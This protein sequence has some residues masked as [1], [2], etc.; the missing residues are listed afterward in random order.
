[1]SFDAFIRKLS[2]RLL[3]RQLNPP[4]PTP[5][6][7]ADLLSPAVAGTHYAKDGTPLPSPVVGSTLEFLSSPSS[8]LS[9]PSVHTRHPLH[10][11]APRYLSAIDTLHRCILFHNSGDAQLLHLHNLH[12]QHTQAYDQAY[13]ASLSDSIAQHILAQDHNQLANPNPATFTQDEA[14]TADPTAVAALDET[15]EG[16]EADDDAVHMNP[17]DLISDSDCSSDEYSD[18]EDAH[19]LSSEEDALSPLPRGEDGHVVAAK[20]RTPRKFATLTVEQQ[21]TPSGFFGPPS[22][23]SPLTGAAEP[24]PTSAQLLADQPRTPEPHSAGHKRH[25]HHH[26]DGHHHHHRSHSGSVSPS[27]RPLSPVPVHGAD[28][29]LAAPLASQRR[30]RHSESHALSVVIPA[31]PLNLPHAAVDDSSTSS[32]AS[33]NPRP[34]AAP[35]VNGIVPSAVSSSQS[36]KA[37]SAIQPTTAST[38]A[39]LTNSEEHREGVWTEAQEAVLLEEIL[40]CYVDVFW[41]NQK[42]FAPFY[43]PKLHSYREKAELIYLHLMQTRQKTSWWHD[44]KADWK[45]RNVRSA[46]LALFERELERRDKEAE[47]AKHP[48][49]FVFLQHKE[50]QRQASIAALLLPAPK[51]APDDDEVE[52][53]LA[54]LPPEP[55]STEPVI[56]GLKHSSSQSHIPDVVEVADVVTFHIGAPLPAVAPKQEPVVQPNAASAASGEWH[57]AL[58]R[59]E[60]EEQEQ[61]RRSMSKNAPTGGSIPAPPLSYFAR[62][63]SVC[64]RLWRGYLNASNTI[65]STI[66]ERLLTPTL[67]DSIVD[68]RDLNRA[69]V[70]QLHTR[71]V[72]S[73]LSAYHPEYQDATCAF[74]GLVLLSRTIRQRVESDEYHPLGLTDMIVA[75]NEVCEILRKAFQRVVRTSPDLMRQIVHS[76]RWATLRQLHEREVVEAQKERERGAAPYP[77]SFSFWLYDSRLYPRQFTHETLLLLRHISQP[78]AAVFYAISAHRFVEA[79]HRLRELKEDVKAVWLERYIRAKK[80]ERIDSLA[81]RPSDK[82][83]SEFSLGSLSRNSQPWR[84]PHASPFA[85]PAASPATSP[86][87]T[88]TEIGHVQKQDSAA[89]LS[90]EYSADTSLRIRVL[91]P[92]DADVPLHAVGAV[93]ASAKAGAEERKSIDGAI[94]P[95]PEPVALDDYDDITA[96]RPEY[97]AGKVLGTRDHT[98]FAHIEK[99]IDISVQYV[100]G[101]GR[102]GPT[103]ALE[104]FAVYDKTFNEPLFD[105]LWGVLQMGL[106]SRRKIHEH[107]MQ[108]KQFKHAESV[109]EFLASVLFSS[110]ATTAQSIQVKEA[111]FHDPLLRW[112]EGRKPADIAH[113][114][115]PISFDDFDWLQMMVDNPEL[116]D[117]V[118]SFTDM[119]DLVNPHSEKRRSLNN[120]T[121]SRQPDGT[122]LLALHRSKTIQ[123]VKVI[124]LKYPMS[125]F[126]NSIVRASFTN[127]IKGGLSGIPFYGP[128]QT[129]NALLER[130]FDFTDIL[131]LQRHQQALL[132][133]VEAM[134]GNDNSPFSHPLFTPELLDK[135][136]FYLLRTNIMLSGVIVN[137]ATDNTRLVTNYLSKI[138]RKREVSMATLTKRGMTLV[139]IPCSYYCITYQR[140][141]DGTLCKLKIHT[142]CFTKIGRSKKPHAAV[143]FFRPHRERRKRL[144]LQYINTGA[145]FLYVPFPGIGGIAKMAYKEAIVREVHKRQ[146]WEN[147]LLAHISHNPGQLSELF[148]THLKVSRAVGDRYEHDAVMILEERSL[149]P[150]DMSYEERE[151][152]RE[153]VENWIHQHDL[154]YRP[155]KP[156]YDVGGEGTKVSAH[157]TGAA[158]GKVDG[159]GKKED[160]GRWFQDLISGNE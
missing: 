54:I 88:G 76:E 68:T 97:Y 34:F 13:I 132:L 146:M 48:F 1:M 148:R 128:T 52:V 106:L 160:S 66:V 10:S 120:C 99:W 158:S 122:Y 84:S 134:H 24:Q 87:H 57:P 131:Y 151:R 96:G 7:S 108:I 149:S 121:F 157:S 129:A 16:A 109:H 111:F 61:R 137:A 74:P 4:A 105:S 27:P 63:N 44:K 69:V 133:V 8:S 142:L 95:A 58:T 3:T 30:R 114:T 40:L 125:S 42:A 117:L 139:L 92:S 91:A 143:D 123:P 78:D 35:T 67:P 28:G 64:R 79:V 22:P 47:D 94:V 127:A 60:L 18:E 80:Q 153:I 17:D 86:V 112:K 51:N 140:D 152:H 5:S 46:V 150:F 29:T 155:L 32:F 6:G 154:D 62:L 102:D 43:K 113:H 85:S 89:S 81:H 103:G 93:K 23:L 36:L 82:S 25:H 135:A 101:F 83:L 37:P 72:L 59:E 126:V 53:E 38:S 141:R 19:G 147:G 49:H 15:K 75:V 56:A 73:R 21:A 11:I 110:N 107:Q 130:I 71:A 26:S 124:D 100:V 33:S 77:E 50:M 98:V 115:K 156:H 14:A 119:N 39:A 65:G 45:A 145:N 55:P 104:P 31:S 90:S 70:Q 144:V 136:A 20:R 138:D 2:P 9:S 12:R 116:Q 159:T 118:H 41:E